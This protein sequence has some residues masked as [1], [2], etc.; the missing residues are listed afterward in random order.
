[1]D[2]TL[3][4]KLLESLK[5][6]P[7]NQPYNILMDRIFH[8]LNQLIE[9]VYSFLH[10]NGPLEFILLDYLVASNEIWVGF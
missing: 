6:P 2:K 1:M 8:R 9:I 5:K 3:A 7:G 4:M 10:N